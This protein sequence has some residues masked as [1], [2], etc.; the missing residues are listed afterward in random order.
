MNKEEKK[1][2]E[3]SDKLLKWMEEVQKYEDE[4]NAFQTE[5]S[6]FQKNLKELMTE[7]ADASLTSLN[8]TGETDITKF[9][10]LLIDGSEFSQKMTDHY[11]R[12]IEYEKT[13]T[14]YFDKIKSLY[15]EHGTK[16]TETLIKNIQSI[17]KQYVPVINTKLNTF[18]ET[19]PI[20]RK[21][22][23]ALKTRYNKFIQ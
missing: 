6:E 3:I 22:Y 18:K 16:T 23:T 5:T 8:Q 1:Y 10:K 19:L 14:E 4:M 21:E 17:E 13:V 15:Q 20:L 9:Q 11:T 2:I 12:R 7:I